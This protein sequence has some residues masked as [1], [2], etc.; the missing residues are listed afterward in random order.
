MDCSPPGSLVHEIFQARTVEFLHHTY[1]DLTF[2]L[3]PSVF[4]PALS[5]TCFS[6]LTAIL[7]FWTCLCYH[8]RNFLCFSI[9]LEISFFSYFLAV[10]LDEVH[11]SEISCKGVQSDNFLC[12]IPN[13]WKY[14]GLSSFFIYTWAGYRIPSWKA[15][16]SEFWRYY[17]LP[18]PSIFHSRKSVFFLL[19]FR[20]SS[21]TNL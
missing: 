11:P 20:I 1:H 15:F 19:K 18:A 8:S 5:W 7:L 6:S 14:L 2:L 4:H 17:C 3:A 16:L 10:L 12:V 9:L 21:S 13:T